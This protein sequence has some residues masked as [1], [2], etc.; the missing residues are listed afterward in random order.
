[1]IEAGT[2]SPGQGRGLVRPLASYATGVAPARL[3]AAV[4]Q[5]P[6]ET[7]PSGARDHPL[8]SQQLNAGFGPTLTP[9]VSRKLHVH[10][11]L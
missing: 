4:A 8:A 1:V 7:L 9:T 10:H 3:T 6:L 5:I 11:Y 2:C